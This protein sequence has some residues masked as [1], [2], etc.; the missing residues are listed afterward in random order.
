MHTC[1]IAQFNVLN[2]IT[3]RIHTC[4][5]TH[6]FLCHA[7]GFY[8]VYGGT[9]N[10][11]Q[12]I[13]D[14]LQHTAPHC[15]TLH[16]TAPHCNTLHRTAT[17]KQEG[18]ATC[19][20]HCNCG[21]WSMKCLPATRCNTLPYTT[22][23]CNTLQHTATYCNTLHHTA[24]GFMGHCN[25]GVRSSTHIPATHYNTLQHATTHCNTL[26]HTATHCNTQQQGSAT[27]MGHCN[28]GA[29]MRVRETRG[30]MM[31]V[32]IGPFRPSVLQPLAKKGQRD[33][34]RERE[35]E[36]VSACV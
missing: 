10:L 13:C 18:S 34:K 24:I 7:S 17:H 8:Y 4:D 5:M 15:T 23:H 16:H 31:V 36:R 11:L 35:R 33:R 12:L 6:P 14:T 19:M 28:C 20:G 22:T 25:C 9:R 1:D 29:Q 32:L 30:V 2:A 27:C 3:S 21:V 26:H